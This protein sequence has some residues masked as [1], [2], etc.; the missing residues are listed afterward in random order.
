MLFAPVVFKPRAAASVSEMETAIRSLVVF[1][2]PIWKL[3]PE[4]EMVPSRSFFPA[5]SVTSE[6]RLISLFRERYSSFR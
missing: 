5:N 1:L 4:P 2:N 6:I 3:T